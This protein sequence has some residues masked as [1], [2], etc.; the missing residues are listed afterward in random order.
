MPL[1]DIAFRR[2]RPANAGFAAPWIDNGS[3]VLAAASRDASLIAQGT[4]E[5][6][7]RRQCKHY[8]KSEDR[9]ELNT[10]TPR[11][12]RS[13]GIQWGTGNDKFTMGLR[14]ETGCSLIESKTRPVRT[15]LV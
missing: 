10:R 5:A 3:D 14:V 8:G 7:R 13:P 4:D 15:K 11:V 6:G 1:T 12:H 2:V 9:Q